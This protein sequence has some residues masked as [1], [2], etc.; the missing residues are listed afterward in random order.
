MLCL[1]SAAVVGIRDLEFCSFLTANFATW[2]HKA[3]AT[4]LQRTKLLCVEFFWS[5]ELLSDPVRSLN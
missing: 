4:D 3:H 1:L 2:G 5:V